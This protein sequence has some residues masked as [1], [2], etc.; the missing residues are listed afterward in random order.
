MVDYKFR[1]SYCLVWRS[2]AGADCQVVEF[3]V[4]VVGFKKL[5]IACCDMS[6]NILGK[7]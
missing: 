7:S 1:H 3:S 4:A 2:V 6:K 5:I